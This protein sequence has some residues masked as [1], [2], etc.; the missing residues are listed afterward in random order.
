VHSFASITTTK[1]TGFNLLIATGFCQLPA[2]NSIILGI[3]AD[4]T[5]TQSGSLP[6]TV[7]TSSAGGVNAAYSILWM[8]GTAGTWNLNMQVANAPAA[9]QNYSCHGTLGVIHTLTSAP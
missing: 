3:T 2:A 4:T 8:P 6:T 7:S 5:S 1:T 9:G